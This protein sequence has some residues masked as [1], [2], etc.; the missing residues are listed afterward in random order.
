MIGGLNDWMIE[1]LK[2]TVSNYMILEGSRD[3]GSCRYRFLLILGA[4]FDAFGRHFWSLGDLLGGIG[5]SLSLLGFPGD[6][7]ELQGSIFM[8]FGSHFGGPWEVSFHVF[9]IINSM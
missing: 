7:W 2:K 5:A 8:D 9:F 3:S 6:P 1:Y 4:V